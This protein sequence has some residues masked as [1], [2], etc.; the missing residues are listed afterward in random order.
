MADSESEA[1]EKIMDI[2]RNEMPIKN[3]AEKSGLS[4]ATASK[5]CHI[6]QAEKKLIIYKFGN[7]KMVKRK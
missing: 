2:V 1:K 6:L 3:I 5:Y 4:I 7:M